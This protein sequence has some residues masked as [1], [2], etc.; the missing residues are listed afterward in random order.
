MWYIGESYTIIS[1]SMFCLGKFVI[2]NSCSGVILPLNLHCIWICIVMFVHNIMVSELKCLCILYNIII[3][4]TSYWDFGSGLLLWMGLLHHCVIVTT[5]FVLICLWILYLCFLRYVFVFYRYN[6]WLWSILGIL[7]W[8]FPVYYLLCHISILVDL[9]SQKWIII[10]LFE[11]VVIWIETH[12]LVPDISIS[13]IFLSKI[14]VFCCFLLLGQLFT[15]NIQH[16][17]KFIQHHPYTIFEQIS[18]FSRFIFSHTRLQGAALITR[19]VV[20]SS[21]FQVKR[22]SI[23]VYVPPIRV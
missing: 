20:L 9:H 16:Y 4:C 19:E 23:L 7:S 13:H 21:I 8:I 22:M 6:P 17:E 3:S 2:Y 18:S 11:L 14:K 5:M 15:L 10:W 1:L 12:I